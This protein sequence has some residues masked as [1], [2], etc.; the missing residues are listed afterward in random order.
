MAPKKRMGDLIEHQNFRIGSHQSKCADKKL[1][2]NNEN[3]S[4]I[5]KF[6]DEFS[7]VSYDLYFYLYLN[8]VRKYICLDLIFGMTRIEHQHVVFHSDCHF[9][10]N[11][12]F[13]CI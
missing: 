7:Y 5:V 6:N 11:F 12:S 9:C 13:L 1:R 8:N 10:Q 4:R 3:T 2:R